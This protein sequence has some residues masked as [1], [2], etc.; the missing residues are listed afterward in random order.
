MKSMTGYGEGSHHARG[1]NSGARS[2]KR[3]C[4]QEPAK[5]IFQHIEILHSTLSIRSRRYRERL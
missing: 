2:D 4:P 5:P 3:L 1:N